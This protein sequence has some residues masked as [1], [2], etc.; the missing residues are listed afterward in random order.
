MRI[1]REGLHKALITK[2][3]DVYGKNFPRLHFY[4]AVLSHPEYCPEYTWVFNVE[5]GINE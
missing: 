5:T 4:L 2:V 1:K 3:S